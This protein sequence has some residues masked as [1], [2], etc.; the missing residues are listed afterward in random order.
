MKKLFLLLAV[1]AL[2]VLNGYSQA[3]TIG[4]TEFIR[5]K[6]WNLG[7]LP[8]VSY[9]SDLGFQYGALANLFYFGEGEIYPDY[10]HSV[11]LEA[12]KYTKGSGFFRVYYDSDYLLPNK[13]VSFD[14]SYLPDDTY[15]F[16][17]FNGLSSIYHENWENDQSERYKS[18]MF[19][20]YQRKLFRIKT[21]LLAP[22][23]D[24]SNFYYIA[25]AGLLNYRIG[26]VDIEK[27]NE[28][29][30]P[31]EQLP[32]VA[33]QPGLYEKYRDWG[34]ISQ[35]E[36]DGG[37]ITFLKSGLVYDSRNRKTNP[38]KGIQPEIIFFGALPGLGE[39]S[40]LKLSLTHRHYVS[41]NKSG[42]LIFA[43]R[44]GYQTT[45]AGSP[46][47]Y[48]QSHLITSFFKSALFEG[49]GG[50][51]SVRGILRN[52]LISDG[53]GYGNFELRWKWWSFALFNQNFYLAFNPFIDMGKITNPIN[54]DTRLIPKENDQHYYQKHP[55]PIHVSYG[56]GLK[57]AMNE[58]FILSADY[59]VAT[60]AQDGNNGF[61]INMN[62]LF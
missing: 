59:G 39:N 55:H 5:K 17:G 16:Y 13:S 52:R 50:E 34:L 26:S 57:I 22:L 8:A 11:Y 41:L 37:A 32:S 21:T 44:L 51:K 46:P 29:Q 30:N 18:R 58:N 7:V 1:G 56:T 49:L 45:I 15:D 43:Y 62:Y 48:F 20:N 38:S 19:Y 10:Y 4:N 24:I 60:K 27:L 14:I 2:F 23:S 25:G 54:V 40:F 9:N 3:D 47:F 61:Y 53:V 6:G 28:G 31:E 36:S 12:S 42:N 35:E 33:E